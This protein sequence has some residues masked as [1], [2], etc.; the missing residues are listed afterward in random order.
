MSLTDNIAGLVVFVG[1]GVLVGSSAGNF[2]SLFWFIFRYI[3]DFFLL[4]D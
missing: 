2:G 3:Y 1:L 4:N